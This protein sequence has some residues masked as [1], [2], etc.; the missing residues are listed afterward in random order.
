MEI[1][2]LRFHFIDNEYVFFSNFYRFL[3]QS[4]G[5]SEKLSTIIS[6][7]GIKEFKTQSSTRKERRA[8]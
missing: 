4:R 7:V 6:L 2:F 1:L 3:I 8:N 5:Q